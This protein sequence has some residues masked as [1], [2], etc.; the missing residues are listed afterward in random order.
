MLDSDCGVLC[1]CVCARIGQKP[2]VCECGHFSHP[3]QVDFDLHAHLYGAR[4]IYDWNLL[5]PRRDSLQLSGGQLHQCRHGT[6]LHL[7]HGY[8][9]CDREPCS[10][11]FLRYI[12]PHY[13]IFLAVDRIC[14][15]RSSLLAH[16]RVHPACLLGIAGTMC[17][18]SSL[19]QI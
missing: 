12:Y 6:C 17:R 13:V 19:R 14:R 16:C 4:L 2:C 10:H 11:P 3:K 1:Q 9:E 5:L 7:F 18:Y 15:F 8:P